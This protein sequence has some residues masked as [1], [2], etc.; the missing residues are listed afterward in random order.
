MRVLFLSF[1]F[2]MLG[3]LCRGEQYQYPYNNLKDRDPLVPLVSESG[4][5]LIQ[6]KKEIGNF[7]LQGIIYSPQNSKAIINNEILSEG[8][9]LGEYRIVKIEPKR[10]VLEKEDKEYILNW[11]VK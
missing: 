10:V 5:I 2:V 3:S 4:H 8:D 6:E 7:I 1:L 11:E 9:V